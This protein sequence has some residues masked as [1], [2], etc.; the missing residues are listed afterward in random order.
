MNDSH[1]GNDI[2]DPE[3]MMIIF[4]AI[5]LKDFIVMNQ[6]TSHFLISCLQI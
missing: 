6:R 4:F 5:M 2:C 1:L 3:M